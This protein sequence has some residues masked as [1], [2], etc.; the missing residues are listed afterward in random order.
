MNEQVYICERCYKK[1]QI[2]TNRRFF[3][4]DDGDLKLCPE[5]SESFCKWFADVPSDDRSD[6]TYDAL[7]RMHGGT[8]K[9]ST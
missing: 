6:G 7:T 8:E 4:D 1:F 5:C 3:G 2:I 9:C